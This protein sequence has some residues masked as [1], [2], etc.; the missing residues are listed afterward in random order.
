MRALVPLLLAACVCPP[1]GAADEPPN[2]RCGTE[3]NGRHEVRWLHRYWSAARDTQVA[4]AAAGP[5]DFRDGDVAVLSDLGDLVAR[6]NPFDLDRLAVRFVPRGAGYALARVAPTL[7]APPPALP[8]GPQGAREVALPFDFPFFGRRQRS[9]FVHAD[10]SLTFERPDGEGGALGMRRFLDGPPRIGALF[11]DL[12]PSRGGSVGVRLGPERVVFAWDGVPGAGQINRNSF[13]AALLPDGQVELAWGEV[14]TR[15]A[16]VG[17]APGGGGELAAADLSQAQ[18]PLAEGAP[19]ERFSERDQIDLV[20]VARRFYAGWP[21]AF[22]Q[23]VVYTTRPLNPLGGTLAFEINVSNVVRGIGLQEFDDSAQWGSAGDLESVVF[24]DAIDPYL[25]VDGFEVLAHEVGHRWLARLRFRGAAAAGSETL[26]RGSVHWSFFLDTDASVMEGNDIEDLGGGR[27]RTV[28]FARGYSALDQY[29]MGLRAAAEVPPVFYVEQADDFR[30]NRTYKA[31]SAPE[32]GV[33][34]TGIRRDV[35]IEDVVA[36]MGPR[37][38]DASRAPRLL[39]QAFVL[40]EDAAA[41]A[42]PV[43]RAALNRI[44]ARFEG[45]FNQAT[46]GRGSALTRLP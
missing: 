18:P 8:L 9:V 37:Q 16:I 5:A 25:D 6:R 4:A 21:D 3:A 35:A 33:S 46:A 12:D 13:Q 42:T 17:L 11:A 10:G 15:E 45:Y 43:R 23:L 38:P 24:M 22:D 41:S 30:P 14:Q 1:I 2:A 26:G 31:S 40:V 29:A 39:R 19:V 7:E 34:F 28:D 20:S 44:R 32:A 36:A 27:F